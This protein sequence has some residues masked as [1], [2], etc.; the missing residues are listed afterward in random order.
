MK[1]ST[2]EFLCTELAWTAHNLFAHPVYQL[3]RCASLFGYIKPIDRL[4]KWIHNATTP[5]WHEH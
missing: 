3:L 4:G 5:T 2:K 1:K